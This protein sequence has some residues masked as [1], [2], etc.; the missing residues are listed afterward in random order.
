MISKTFYGNDKRIPQFLLFAIIDNEEI[1][2]LEEIWWKFLH[3]TYLV[4]SM[5]LLREFVDAVY[6]SSIIENI[7]RHLNM[8]L[9]IS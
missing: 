3:T 7:L 9:E 2:R 8:S 5:N 6:A 4:K 1:I